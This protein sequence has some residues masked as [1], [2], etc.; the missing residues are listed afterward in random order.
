MVL[1]YVRYY[2]VVVLEEVSRWCR[3]LCFLFYHPNK[4]CTDR[5]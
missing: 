4:S 5:C 2:S 3:S 1:S